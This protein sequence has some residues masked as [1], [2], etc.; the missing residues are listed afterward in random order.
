MFEHHHYLT[1]GF[2]LFKWYIVDDVDYL[3]SLGGH[4]DKQ[5]E[6]EEREEN[7]EERTDE[8]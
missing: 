7:E 4:I 8:D 1:I 5:G 6:G 3:L 2:H